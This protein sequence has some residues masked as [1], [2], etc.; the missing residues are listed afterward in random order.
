MATPVLFFL[1]PPYHSVRRLSGTQPALGTV[2][3][4]D[5][6]TTR[7]TSAEVKAQ[8]EVAPWC[9]LCLLASPDGGFRSLRRLTRTC[10]AFGIDTGDG[11]TAI[12]QAVAQ[13]PRPT[14]SDLAEWITRR[15]RLPMMA[16]LVAEIFARP[17]YRAGE[18]TSLPY[19]TR[20]QLRQLGMFDAGEW[21]R[22]AVLTELAADRSLMNRALAAT[23]LNSAAL[24][25]DIPEL[26]DMSL[27]GFRDR[28]G[29]EWVLERALQ[30]S[31]FFDGSPRRVTA[32]AER[33]QV[34][35]S[36]G[37]GERVTA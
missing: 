17:A 14:A 18:A 16:R 30:R 19:A 32:R 4:L 22:V 31:G 1:E 35:V 10:V 9:P 34:W 25:S 37:R 36:G 11:A 33:E 29:W 6:S 12:L 8:M 13:R 3:L 7:F 2:A 15:A 24:R 23:D 26:L 28:Y 27:D 5:A 21:Q 20:E